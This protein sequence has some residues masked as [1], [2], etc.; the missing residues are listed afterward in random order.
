MN[1]S[2]LH[3]I[4]PYFNH[5]NAGVNHRNLELCLRH[6]SI[7]TDCLVVLV[8]GIWNR[9]A[10][11]PDFSGRIF[12]HLKFDLSNA[13]WVKENLINL[14]IASLGEEWEYAAWIDKDLLF[15][16][17]DWVLKTMRK[18]GE[19]DLIQP[20]SRCL[21]LDGSCE[22][23]ES[24]DE[25]QYLTEGDPKGSRS[26]CYAREHPPLI[27]CRTGMAWAIRK[28]FYRRIGKLFDQCIIGGGDAGMTASINQRSDLPQLQF[29]GELFRDY[30]KPFHGVKT[31]Y[32]N[33]SIVHHYH[34]ETKRR[35]YLPRY[36]LLASWG[37]DGRRDLTYAENGT[38]RLSNP[39]VEKGIAEYFHSREEYLV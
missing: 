25:R 29:Y 24:E 19:C 18:L 34:G 10:E 5:T 21:S 16:D 2:K 3:V 35:F 12:R 9:K 36:A 37:F 22:I 1:N 15:L 7:N 23:D 8:E 30:S 13:I 6:L 14:G 4:I 17:P 38:L 27:P 32:L 11:L 28:S 39:V 33:G 26:F 20:W 31:G